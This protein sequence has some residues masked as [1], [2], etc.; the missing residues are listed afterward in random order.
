M[1]RVMQIYGGR[2]FWKVLPSIALTVTSTNKRACLVCCYRTGNGELPLWKTQRKKEETCVRHR[3]SF[4]FLLFMPIFT[5]G[6]N[7]VCVGANVCSSASLRYA[8]TFQSK[9]RTCRWNKWWELIKNETK[10]NNQALWVCWFM[11][12]H[13][14]MG[15]F[16]LWGRCMRNVD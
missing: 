8:D 13:T 9:M 6:D 5:I 3:L 1:E 2:V 7:D 12:E 16:G 11:T 10:T 14:Q 4:G 15:Q